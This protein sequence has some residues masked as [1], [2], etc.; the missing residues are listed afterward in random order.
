MSIYKQLAKKYNLSEKEIKKICDSP[1]LLAKEII[2]GTDFNEDV[3]DTLN[4]NIKYLGTF[5]IKDNKRRAIKRK[6]NGF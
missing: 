6:I 1:F 3:G 4:F 2:K 5:H